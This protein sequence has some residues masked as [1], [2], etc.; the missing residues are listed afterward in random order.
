[1]PER[2]VSFTVTPLSPTTDGSKFYKMNGQSA[3][4]PITSAL[5]LVDTIEE[6]ECSIAGVTYKTT[7][8]RL[9]SYRRSQQLICLSKECKNKLMKL[10][11][12]MQKTLGPMTDIIGEI[13]IIRI[14]GVI[15]RPPLEDPSLATW[16]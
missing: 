9:N 10:V 15:K 12:E 2:A 14:A 5:L 13:E 11:D 6:L 8:V 16:R 3:F 1:M 7:R 4:N